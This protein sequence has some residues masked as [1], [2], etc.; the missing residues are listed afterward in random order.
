M[1][2]RKGVTPLATLE[3]R[4]ITSDRRRLSFRQ[5]QVFRAIMISGSINAAAKTLNVSQP[6]LSRVVRRAEDVLGFPLFERAKGRLVPT[7]DANLLLTLVGRVY[8]QL[9]ELGDAIERMTRGAGVLFRVGSTPSPGR[10][11]VPQAIARLHE[12]YPDLGFHVDVLLVDQIIDYLTMHRGE[13]VVSIFPVR[14]A[15]IQSKAIGTAGLVC[16]VPR[17]HRLAKRTSVRVSDLAAEYMIFFES[18]TPHGAA[19]EHLFM[20]VNLEPRVGVRIRHIETAVGLVA[21]GLGIA[22]VDSISVLDAGSLPFSVIPIE[23]SAPLSVHLN[24]NHETSRSQFL[25]R[26]E[27]DLI[28]ILHASG[29]SSKKARIA[30]RTQKI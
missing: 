6:N 18:E 17:D 11:L 27:Q 15:L 26:F 1:P 7:K 30:R 12:V 19:A 14:H 10:C 4:D 9:D 28:Q 3:V 24:W 5:V 20:G 22:L 13:C 29:A 23:N 8:R 2:S 16:L 21:S 25:R